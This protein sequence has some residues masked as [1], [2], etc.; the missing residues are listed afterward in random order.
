MEYD[1][2][3][4]GAGPAGLGCAVYAA[5]YDLKIVVVGEIP[6]GMMTEA[7]LID[8]YLGLPGLNGMEMSMKFIEHVRKFGVEIRAP[9]KI[10][11]VVK[12]GA[13]F[14][15]RTVSAVLKGKAI[16]VALG[17][18]KAGLNI[19]GEEEFRGKGVS[20]CATCDGILFSGMDVAIFGGENIAVQSALMLAGYCTKVHLLSDKKL[21]CDPEFLAK[22]MKAKNVEIREGVKITQIYGRE[23]A[24]GL[25]FEKAGKQYDIKVS[26]I[27]IEAG[28]MP[29]G[30]LL[31][32]LGVRMDAKGMV[33]VDGNM[34][35][36]V[37]GVFAAGDITNASGGFRQII[38]AVAGGA[39][40]SR[41]VLKYIRG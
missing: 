1:L 15:V 41:S 20:Y 29:S 35:T 34:A 5:R 25:K 38:T 2:I 3:I 10:F 37:K 31:R 32:P 24:E 17:M 21:S 16:L 13:V 8:N 7:Y 23:M 11:S 9:E 18:K 40:A 33:E 39:V 14:E 4:L 19:P 30:E 26:G 22:A 28:H 36:N 6:G 27:F 12:S